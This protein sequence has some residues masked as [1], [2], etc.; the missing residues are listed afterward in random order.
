MCATCY[1]SVYV[2]PYCPT[3]QRSETRRREKQQQQER[4]TGEYVMP[5]EY[6]MSGD[7]EEDGYEIAEV[8]Q[9]AP[10]LVYTHK[11][12]HINTHTIYSHIFVCTITCMSDCWVIE[13]FVVENDICSLPI[14]VTNSPPHTTHLYS[15]LLPFLGNCKCLFSSGT[16]EGRT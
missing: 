5:G 3:L 14:G 11:H 13:I 10:Y 1:V 4:E 9:P 16:K 8:P 12:T 6:V 7:K 2:P 15:S